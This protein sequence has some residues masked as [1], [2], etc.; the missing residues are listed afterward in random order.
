MKILYF[1]FAI[2]ALSV[3]GMAAVLLREGSEEAGENVPRVGAYQGD[4]IVQ[5]SGYL[6]IE[7]LKAF[8][9]FPVYW[10][11]EHFH[12]YEIISIYYARDPGPPSGIRPPSEYIAIIYGDCD[13]GKRPEG[14]CVPFFAVTNDWLCYNTPSQLVAG[15][16]S[17]PPFE[18]RGALA[19]QTESGNLHIYTKESTIVVFSAE[20]EVETIGA[21]NA[22]RGA[23]VKGSI[24]TSSSADPLGAPIS[25]EDCSNMTLPTV[26]P[27][28]ADT[29]TEMPTATQTPEP[30]SEPPQ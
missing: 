17:G 29:P 27:S 1:F 12:G 16:R 6:T 30:T 22:L 20:G 24:H 10:L 8:D 28:P 2:V 15:A 4:V 21:T 25:E 7:E 18:I 5:G 23:N 14:R 9:R 13:P 19:Q 11:G 3:G 26:E